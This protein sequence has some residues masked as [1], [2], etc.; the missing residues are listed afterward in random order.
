MQNG[1]DLEKVNSN[2][3]K[4]NSLANKNA[5]PSGEKE[6]NKNAQRRACD[7]QG[8][9]KRRLR[10]LFFTTRVIK[11]FTFNSCLNGLKNEKVK[12]VSQL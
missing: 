9:V 3:I 8:R 10:F 7:L 5:Q 12:K 6:K 1:V 11:C 2:E 4:N